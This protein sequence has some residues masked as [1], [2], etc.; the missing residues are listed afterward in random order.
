MKHC[1]YCGAE[2]ASDISYCTECRAE[3][4]SSKVVTDRNAASSEYTAPC[5]ECGSEIPVDA[6]RCSK[7]G[8][9][10][11]LSTLNLV[12]SA[13]A[14][15]IL[16]PMLIFTIEHISEIIWGNQFIPL[17]LLRLFVFISVSALPLAYLYKVYKKSKHKPAKGVRGF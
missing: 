8:Y 4:G 3:I 6:D 13:V 17:I 14:V 7:C 10:P 12:G 2:V 9:E 1:T 5:K 15:A 11:G 16:S